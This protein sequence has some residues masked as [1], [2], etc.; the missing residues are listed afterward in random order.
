[1]FPIAFFLVAGLLT[2]LGIGLVVEAVLTFYL[3]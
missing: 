1:M 2:G 3:R